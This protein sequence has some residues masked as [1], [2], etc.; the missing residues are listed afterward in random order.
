MGP[1]TFMFNSPD[2]CVFYQ[3]LPR[4]LTE[5]DVELVGFVRGDA[6]EGKDY[7]REDAVWLWD[8]ATKKD[9]Y[10]N[11]RNNAGVN[12][13][14]FEPGPYHPEFEATLQKFVG[15]YL[16]HLEEVSHV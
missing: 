16:H 14:C 9:D 8:H 11:L 13:R 12:S 15:W 7:N 3:F 6:E 10:I 5:T 1:L 2:H 4:S